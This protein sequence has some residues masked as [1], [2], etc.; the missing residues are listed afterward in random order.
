MTENEVGLFEAMRTQRAIRHYK[1][2]PVPDDAV[3]RILEA[4]VRAPSGANAQP[5]RFIVIRDPRLK[6][7]VAHYYR[8]AV[9]DTYGPALEPP[10]A[11]TTSPAAQRR[12]ASRRWF[13]EHFGDIPVLILVC[14]DLRNSPPGTT[15]HQMGSS[16]YPAV[17]NL[18]LAA[19][20]LGLGTVL[21]TIYKR[22]DAEIKKLLG[23]PEGVETAC[24][25]PLGY[26]ED[27]FGGSKRRPLREVV[28]YDGWERQQAG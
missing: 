5:W 3:T 8:Q 22:Y 4:A 6:Q 28:F 26:P 20:G 11:D 13:I 7:Q 10:Y 12:M 18:M 25:I 19:R 1:L 2:D 9:L 24:L 16:I 14:V 23:I 17:Q 15:V 21:T 27:R